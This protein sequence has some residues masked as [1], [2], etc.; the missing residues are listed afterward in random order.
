M[1]PAIWDLDTGTRVMSL[2]VRY[3]D[4]TALAL[5]SDGRFAASADESGSVQLWYLPTGVLLRSLAR[6]APGCDH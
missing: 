2:D 4:V 6:A 1:A 5:T 3:G